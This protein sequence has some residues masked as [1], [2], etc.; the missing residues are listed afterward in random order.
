MYTPVRYGGKLGDVRTVAVPTLRNE[1]YEAGIEYMVSDALRRE[2]LRRK[3]VRLVEDPESADLVLS[4]SVQPIAASGRSFS[5]VVLSL[6]YEVTLQ[7]EIE[8]LRPDG[9]KVHIDP[10][11]LSESERYL[12]SAD[13]EAM[14][15]N[16]QEALRELA[17]VLAGRI[18]D[19]LYETLVP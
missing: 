14:R 17:S 3:G 4:G 9:T 12:A 16:R 7:L 19:A 13:V 18:Y 10:R 2:V 1:S 15:K 8:A 11:A 6:E 5:S